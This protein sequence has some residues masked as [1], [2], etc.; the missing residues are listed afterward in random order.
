MLIGAATHLRCRPGGRPAAPFGGHLPAEAFRAASGRLAALGFS[1]EAIDIADT[2]GA[3]EPLL[4]L[5]TLEAE[6]LGTAAA[7]LLA[8][9]LRQAVTDRI[10]LAMLDVSGTLAAIDC[11]G[12]R[13]DQLR[14]LLQGAESRRARRLGIASI[15][16]GALTAA[17]SGG[18][19]AAGTAG[20]GS[21]AGIAGGAAEASVAA[22]LLFGS[23]TGELRTERNLLR[24]CGNGRRG[25]TCS[26][27]RSGGS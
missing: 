15:M 22:S 12:E 17:L 11:E 4:Q 23:A 2:I 10:L 14:V 9:R 7:E 21:A 26:R 16:V 3:A 20:A 18:L 8:L 1:R 27:H 5:A 25:R 24:E 6:A 19:S 13:G